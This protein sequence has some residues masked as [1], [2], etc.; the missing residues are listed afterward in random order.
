VKDYFL[1]VWL[2]SD[3]QFA[4]RWQPMLAKHRPQQITTVEAAAL[5]WPVRI[6][7]AA[8]SLV[9]VR[10]PL[11]VR[12]AKFFYRH[13]LAAKRASTTASSL[14]D[15]WRHF[16]SLSAGKSRINLSASELSDCRRRLVRGSV[17]K[18]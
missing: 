11:A 12:F 5:V 4:A 7:R 15:G 13:D 3:N 16:N 10:T 18:P 17:C 2:E 8:A 1:P 9:A 6:N 14:Y